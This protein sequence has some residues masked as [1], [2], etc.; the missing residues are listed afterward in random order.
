MVDDRVLRNAMEHLAAADSLLQE[1]RLGGS[2]PQGW[3]E[4]VVGLMVDS[5]CELSVAQGGIHGEFDDPIAALKNK[6]KLLVSRLQAKA[7]AAER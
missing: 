5:A 6:I 3:L 2:Y 1:M 7:R 4:D